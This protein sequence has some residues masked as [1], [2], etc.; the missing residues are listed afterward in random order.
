MQVNSC[1][2]RL[3]QQAVSEVVGW[4][5]VKQISLAPGFSQVVPEAIDPKPFQ[6]FRMKTVPTADVRSQSPE[7]STEGC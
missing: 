3:R 5:E 4:F 2:N 1:R 7:H 6:R